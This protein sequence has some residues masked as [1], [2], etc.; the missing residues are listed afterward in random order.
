MDGII[1]ENEPLT[2][3]QL[4]LDGFY[5]RVEGALIPTPV[6]TLSGGAGGDL[7]LSFVTRRT[8]SKGFM[9]DA[10][11]TRVSTG[12]RMPLGD[13]LIGETGGRRAD[14]LVAAVNL[15]ADADFDSQT[16]A[17]ILHSAY[18]SVMRR[19][20]RTSDFGTPDGAIATDPFALAPPPAI[21]PI[22]LLGGLAYKGEINLIAA[23]GGLGKSII[24]L[25][26]GFEMMDDYEGGVIWLDTERRWQEF[27]TRTHRMAQGRGRTAADYQGRIRYYESARTAWKTREIEE[28]LR[29][30]ADGGLRNCLLVIDSSTRSVESVNSQK[31]VDGLHDLLYNALDF[32]RTLDLD[33]TV[34]ECH[35][36]SKAERGEESGSPTPT[37]NAAWID[38]PRCV[39]GAARAMMLSEEADPNDSSKTQEARRAYIRVKLIKWNG[40]ER[41]E[42]TPAGVDET[43]CAYDADQ[44]GLRITSVKTGGGQWRTAPVVECLPPADWHKVRGEDSRLRKAAKARSDAEKAAAAEAREAERTRMEADARTAILAFADG[45]A[46][47]FAKKDAQGA[48]KAADSAITAAAA[49]T[50]LDELI[51]TGELV[52]IGAAYGRKDVKYA[53]EYDAAKKAARTAL[54][55]GEATKGELAKALA[56]A[57]GCGGRKA[58]RY[59]ERM[60]ADALI[61]RESERKPYKWAGE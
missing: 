4:A 54:T 6:F 35:H 47:P 39:Q 43:H 34:L 38:R 20:E 1:A 25:A 46:K 30:F 16:A 13:F 49:K 42:E 7:E 2:V 9:T 17:L 31:E 40:G 41:S 14:E 18:A 3:P 33:L 59:I 10:T 15:K 21:D 51:E 23:Q 44:M 61:E 22:P 45:A 27:L 53:D 56:K 32:A 50:A 52:K 60:D 29:A 5:P 48:V 24:A 11:L 8:D 19:T 57:L 26:L 55:L 37:G 58:N 12:E 36:V 28:S